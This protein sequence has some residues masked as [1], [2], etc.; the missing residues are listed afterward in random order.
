MSSS[1]PSTLTSVADLFRSANTDL[2]CGELLLY[3][4]ATQGLSGQ[5][6]MFIMMKGSIRR[7]HQCSLVQYIHLS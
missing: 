5:L 7:R 3:S 2:H 1:T 4:V 6:L